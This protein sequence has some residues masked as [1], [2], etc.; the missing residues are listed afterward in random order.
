[1]KKQF[2]A[3]WALTL[4]FVGCDLFNGEDFNPNDKGKLE[5]SFDNVVGDQ[6]LTLTTKSYT[7]A[8]GEQFTVSMLK[9]F[10]SNI[11]L[12]NEDGTTFTYPQDNSY[13]LV[14][15][16]ESA[17]HTLTLQDVPA[18][19]YKAVTFTV[20]V[21]SLR[22]T[23]DVAKRI[24]VLDIAGDAK[25][26]YW[27]W[28]SGYIFFKMEGNSPQVAADANGDHKF[29]YHIGL[30][31]GGFGTP[32]VKTINNVKNTTLDLGT[33]R[34]KVRKDDTPHVEVKMDV[35]KVFKGVNTLSLAKSSV[36]MASP[37]S[38]DVA[39][40]YIKAFSFGG[41]HTH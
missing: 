25:D 26:M 27:K 38:A 6:D 1:M 20:G 13:F 16:D 7:N 23:M 11:K 29:Y 32:V 17:T 40:N 10:I 12:V 4:S 18:G 36:I 34:A 30:Y 19:N 37:N 8:A 15:E 28:N 2:I 14:R 41:L 31:G 39:N 33:E 21:D 35:A 9:Y 22:N 3:F 24:G 5:I